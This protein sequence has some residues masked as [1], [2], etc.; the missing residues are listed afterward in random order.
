[1]SGPVSLQRETFELLREMEFFTERELT[2]QIGHNRYYWP[3]A[4]LKELLD[5][6]LDACESADIAPV[7][8]A[9]LQ[10][11]ALIVT[12]NG[13]GLPLAT[14]EGSLNYAVRVSDKTGYVSP[15]RGQQGNALKTLWAAPF[16]VTGEGRITIETADYRR[17]VRVTLDRIAQKPR[18][19]CVDTGPTDVKSGTKIT[20]HW[21]NIAGWLLAV[22]RP[23]QFLQHGLRSDGLQSALRLDRDQRRE[24]PNLSSDRA[25]LAT[26][27]TRPPNRPVAGDANRR[28][29]SETRGART[30]GTRPPYRQCGGLR[31]GC[32]LGGISPRAG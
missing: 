23:A 2:A 20:L 24:K 7:I 9:D 22:R 18:L 5:N 16:V 19:E 32:G 31:R 15:S 4:L 27:A 30:A 11:D 12:D 17:G 6:A 29:P 1:M 28:P 13:P 14:L 8:T 26:L 25:G 10:E 3:V 21:K